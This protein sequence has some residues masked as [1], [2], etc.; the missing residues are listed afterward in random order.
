MKRGKFHPHQARLLNA[1]QV[2]EYYGTLIAPGWRGGLARR[3]NRFVVGY[4]KRLAA[5]IGDRYRLDT[6]NIDG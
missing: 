3:L 1:V 5:A 2:L 4:L 6:T